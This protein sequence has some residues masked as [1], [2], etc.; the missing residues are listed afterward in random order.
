MADVLQKLSPHRDLQCYFERPSAIAA[1]SETSASGFTVSGCWRQQFDW[2]VVEWNRDNVFEHPR[3][4][5][6]PDGDLSGLQLIYDE[7]RTNCIPLDATWYPT[8]DWPYLRIW[9]DQGGQEQV[10][11]VRLLDHATAVSGSYGAATATFE[12]HGLPTAGDYIELAWLDEHHTYQLYGADTLEDA[13]QAIVDSINSFSTTMTASRQ[14]TLITLRYLESAGANA[15]RI[16]IYANVSGAQTESWEPTWQLLS[17]GTSP[18]RWRISLE[19][20][21]LVDINGVSVPSSAV[22]KL[23]WTY[24]ADV[25]TAAFMRTE[26]EVVVSNWTV[27]GTNRN[28]L[29]SGPGSRRI[30]DDYR[31]LTYSGVWTEARGNFSGGSIRHTTAPGAFVKSTYNASRTH[32]LYLGTRRAPSCAAVAIAVDGIMVRT[33]D[34]ALLGEDV[35][36][37]LPL[38]QFAGGIEHSVAITHNGAA[39]SYLYFDFLEVSVP[40]DVVPV[41]AGDEQITLATDWDTDHS[42]A[43][44]PERSAWLI[45]SLGFRG[46]ANHYAGALWFYELACPGHHYAAWD[47]TLEGVPEFGKVIELEI[48]PTN[49]EHVCL[50]GDTAASVAKALELMVNAG[51]TGVWAR[52]E[53]STLRIQARQMGTSGNGTEINVLTHS[54]GFT[55]MVSAVAGGVDGEW[56]TDLTAAPLINRAARDW[57]RSFIRAMQGYGIEVVAAFSTELQHGDPS[58]EAGIAQR[59]P[60]GSAVMVNTPALQTNFSPVSLAF[61][62]QV[63]LDMADLF[64]AAGQS[65]FLQFGEVQWWYFPKPGVG[66]TFY[67]DYTTTTFQTSY[68]RPLPVF[69]DGQASPA[70]F[71]DECEFLSGLIGKFTDSIIDFVRQTYATA[72]FEVLYPPDTNE[73]PLNRAVNLAVGHW[74]PARMDC[75]KTENFTFTGNRDLDKACASVMLPI[76][77]G[78]TPERSAHLVGIGDYTTPWQKEADLAQGARLASVVLF[79]LDQFCLIGYDPESRSATTRSLYMG[80]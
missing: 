65:P 24:A 50:I 38:G 51:S 35:L 5:N 79:A 54:S 80:A 63:Y 49:I 76:E 12:L 9:A 73:A 21:A 11:K 42:M 1:L 57:H 53:G 68:G 71:P 40:T 15:N 36:V 33:E 27:T 72:R 55:A 69:L 28:Y 2:A 22:R 70:A 4:R 64:S 39:G 20:G 43:L 78:F 44:A 62:R 7:T 37:R 8:V 31:E 18:E 32:T 77:L 26:F 13:A 14:E 3:F 60:D 6:L 48:G 10:Y 66:M 52:A 34:L 58:L 75:L 45:H 74:T 16:G 29:V 46:R 61:W 67:D 30:E 23:R 17:G 56:R 59:Y 19:F 25:Q 41:F 47:V